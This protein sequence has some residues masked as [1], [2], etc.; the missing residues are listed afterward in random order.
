M[1]TILG[2][3]MK[4]SADATG[5]QQSLTPVERALNSLSEQAEKSAAAFRPLAR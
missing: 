4:I 5:V 2:L 1:A 3:A